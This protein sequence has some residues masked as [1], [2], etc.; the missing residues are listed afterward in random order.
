M[1]DRVATALCVLGR[2]EVVR[3]GERVRLGSGQQRRLLAVLV[4]H[5][6]EVVSRDRLVDVLWGDGPPPSATQ[7]LQGLVSRLRAT[8][9]EDR[10]ETCPPGYRL[11]VAIDEVDALRFE[12]LVRVGLGSSKRPAVALDV[13]DEAL[14]L[15]RGL[16]YAEFA[17]EECVAAEVAR[18]V[19]LRARVI[20]ER[21]GALLE[22]S[23]PEDV[24]GE[25][26][27]QIAVEP[28]RE[29]L[30]ALL[31]LALA[32]AGR[33]VESL[34]AY[35]AFRRFLADEVGVVPS[36][37]LQV[38][39]DDILRQ[40][41]DVGWAGSPTNDP[42]TG[43]LPSG[44]VSFLL[45]DVEDSTRL[46]DES[47]DVM[48]NAMPR[49]DELLRDAVESHDGVIV[50]D[51]GDGFHA[52]F[53]TAHD[54]V[55]AAVAAQRGLLADDWNIAQTV[56]VRMGIHTGEVEVRDG[57]YSGGAVNRAER[58]MSVAHGG[59]IVVSTTT[60]ELLHDA[61]PEKYG[62]IDLGEHRLRDL[63]RPEHLF[64][65]THPDLEWEFAA[66]GT[67]EAFPRNNLPR[68]MTTF[69]GRETEIA[70]VAELVC[71][72]SLVTLTGLGG[73]GKTRLA[74]QA[75]EEVIREFPDGA[76]LC[77]FAPVT[78]PEAVWATVASSVRVQP[79][80][81][82]ALAL[83][84]L[85]FLAAKRL[86]LVL[87]NCEH[88]LDAVARL[89]DAIEQRCARVSVLATSRE[90][91]GLAG[92]RIMAV[93]PLGVPAGDADV[94]EVRQAEAVCLFG[95]RASTAK[96]DFALTDRNVG[97]AGVLCRRLDGIPLAIELAAAR[98]RSLSPEDLVARLD[99]RFTL[100]THGSRAA[101]ERHQ[102]LRRTIDWSYDLLTPTERRALQRL[103]VFAGGCDLA[104]AEAVLPDHDLD[105]LDVVDVIGQL[106]DKSLVVTD[107]TDGGVRYRLLETI[108]QYARE[109]LNASGDPI[110]L[111]RRHADHYVALAEAAGPHLRAREHLEW[112]SVVTVDIDNFRAALDW[113][114][115]APS[116][117][118][119]L[120]LVAPLAVQG[121][122][123][124]L[125][126][127]WAATA[128]AIPG[129]DGHPLVPAVA[130][131]AALTATLARDF[132]QAEDL[133]GVAERAQAA[134]GTR[135]W[136]VARVRTTLAHFRDDFAEARRHGEEL[137]ELARA[138][139]D[140][141]ELAGAFITYGG[142]LHSAETLD[143]AV[144]A[145]EESVRV[146]R[147][148]GID[149]TLVFALSNLAT[150]LPYEESQRALTL[151]D[152]AIEVSTRIGERLDVSYATGIKAEI[153]ARH[154]DWRT[155]LQISVEAAEQM[156]EL[157]AYWYMT[158]PLYWAGVALCALGSY[159]PAAVV[160]GNP[161]AI[162]ERWL[163]E[164]IV[165]LGAA[166]DATLRETL[167]QQQVARL[168]ARGAALDITDAVA[169]VHAEADRALA[170]P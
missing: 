149:N 44:T 148:G 13:F 161:N 140:P 151:L 11:R 61:L 43:H 56:R 25:L 16:P 8:L 79:G 114:V 150:W 15:W 24:L 109:R 101:L 141:Y 165:E 77:E 118:H 52:V 146:A 49:H 82:R 125:T 154:G 72:S 75:A 93:P 2:L 21:A 46:W 98:V 60:E 152:E 32:R 133:L 105:A 35:D 111:R 67:L 26:E 88:L 132:A 71:R 83:S 41:P 80:P 145:T 27:A 97:A 29:R 117:E 127:G 84:V 64:Q 9:G 153:A 48:S 36:P 7:T 3:H 167:G 40:H 14:G 45:T 33:P 23:R 34:R 42:H 62:F 89:V 90:G 86:L 155:A 58:L 66:L 156:L 63:G 4:V 28:F 6:N 51:A 92:E 10:L 108:R 74:L 136:S 123:R 91:L 128:L 20:E 110:A 130:A 22:L 54:A 96:R 12:E 30:R 106:V 69:V 138:S 81:G 158:R 76:W 129:G 65:V 73:V 116:P 37:G 38:L 1:E 17:S 47:P 164:W 100:L 124:E 135:L 39:N 57:D 120:R 31:M 78:D 104:A 169:Y 115:E 166:T 168:A 19:E 170:A 102:T 18:L 53:A 131:W 5:A 85:D 103:S 143:A 113:A 126:L 122:P 87:D 144:A 107:D 162:T 112:T 157:G 50:K 59:Q 142:A 160:L 94:N 55:S 121:R 68:Q 147:A 159:E 99:Q 139:G 163:P 119:A 95:D 134:L 70:S 137:V